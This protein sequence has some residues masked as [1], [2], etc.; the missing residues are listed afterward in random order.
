MRCWIERDNLARYNE[1][2]FKSSH[3]LYFQQ[4]DDERKN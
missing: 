4:R 1:N 3:A 2:I